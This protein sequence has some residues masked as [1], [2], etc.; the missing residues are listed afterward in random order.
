LLFIGFI[1]DEKMFWKKEK[2]NNPVQNTL[3]SDEFERL[4][5]RIIDINTELEL[6]KAKNVNLIAGVED[7]RRKFSSRIKAIIEA[8][9]QEPTQS[10]NTSEEIPF[11]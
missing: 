5:K 3:H 6:L 11:G 9:K 4:S 8:E 2:T 10:L 1:T 7:L